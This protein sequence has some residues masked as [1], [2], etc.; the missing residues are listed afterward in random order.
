V[1]STPTCKG[2]E[3]ISAWRLQ[4]RASAVGR[5]QKAVFGQERTLGPGTPHSSRIEKSR[6]ITS[7]ERSMVRFSQ[8]LGRSFH[9]GHECP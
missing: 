1:T 7:K 4:R 2:I 8:N 6:L 5:K 9:I 3:S